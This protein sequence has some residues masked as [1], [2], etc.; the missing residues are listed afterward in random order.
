M[1]LLFTQQSGLA[2]ELALL[3][4]GTLEWSYA[5]FDRLVDNHLYEL[6]SLRIPIFNHDL[7]GLAP[8]L[9]RFQFLRNLLCSLG[10]VVGLALLVLFKRLC[11][12]GWSILSDLE[13]AVVCFGGFIFDNDGSFLLLSNRGYGQSICHQ[14]RL[15]NHRNLL[16]GQTVA[17]RP[18][19]GLPLLH[20]VAFLNDS[21]WFCSLLFSNQR[22]LTLCFSPF[23]LRRRL[24]TFSHSLLDSWLILWCWLPAL[25]EVSS[26][27]RVEHVSCIGPNAAAIFIFVLI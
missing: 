2:L 1:T 12:T 23:S 21:S 14:V 20:V 11:G 27:G 3:K 22:L 24:G 13:K 16:L 19:Q 17:L 15:V 5:L 10:T 25:D 4:N 6:I 8:L 26:L 7:P 18:R 9:F